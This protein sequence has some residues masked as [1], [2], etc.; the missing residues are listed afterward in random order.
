M[1]GFVVL[2]FGGEMI[3]LGI[4]ILGK[5]VAVRDRKSAKSLASMVLT[6]ID[7]KASSSCRL[8]RFSGTSF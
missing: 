5:C 2:G 7:L 4:W 6:F 1:V 3:F 8:F